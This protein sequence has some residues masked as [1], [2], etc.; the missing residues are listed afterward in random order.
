MHESWQ[1]LLDWVWHEVG[2]PANSFYFTIKSG[3]LHYTYTYD[4]TYCEHSWHSVDTS[5]PCT[6]QNSYTKLHRRIP[7]VATPYV[8]LTQVEKVCAKIKQME[9]RRKQPSTNQ[10]KVKT[11]R[12]SFIILD[13][14]EPIAW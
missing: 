7:F 4:T 13:D 10:I 5:R 12:P 2:N 8:E 3:V 11:V 9:E 14:I 1:E 6:L